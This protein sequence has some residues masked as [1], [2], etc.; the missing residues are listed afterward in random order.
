MSHPYDQRNFI[1]AI[2]IARGVITSDVLAKDTVSVFSAPKSMSDEDITAHAKETMATTWHMSR[3]AKM[4]KPED[5]TS[6]VDTHF[7]GKGVRGSAYSG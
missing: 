7:Q 2:R 5:P 1:E 4:G 3:T 6:V